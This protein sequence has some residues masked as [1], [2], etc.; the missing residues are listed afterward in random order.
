MDTFELWCWRRPENPSDSKE[1]KPVNPK[2]KQTW[3]FIGRCWSWSSN[4]LVTW[5]KELTHWK[6]PWCWERLRAREGGGRGWD[7]WIASLTQWTWVWANFGRWWRTEEPDMLQSMGSQT[8]GHDWVTEQQHLSIHWEHCVCSNNPF[9]SFLQIRLPY[10]ADP[11]V[12]YGI[13]IHLTSDSWVQLSCLYCF[14]YITISISAFCP[15]TPSPTL[16]PDL[17]ELATTALSDAGTPLTSAFLI[18]LENSCST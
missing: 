11:V 6:R 18:A 9:Q 5:C 8:V 14:R 10:Y 16:S 4:T 3:I 13:C 7:G 12:H 17:H 1:I 2:G 15:V